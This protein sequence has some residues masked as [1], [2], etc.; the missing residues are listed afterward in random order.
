MAAVMP[1]AAFAS[2]ADGVTGTPLLDS[3]K[4]GVAT[5]RFHI[6]MAINFDFVKVNANLKVTYTPLLIGTESGDTA[7]FTPVMLTGHR[8]HILHSRADHGFKGIELQRDNGK[9]QSIDYAS[10]VSYEPWMDNSML[11]LTDDLCG[12]GEIM[13]R[14]RVPLLAIAPTPEPEPVVLECY[15]TPEVEAVKHRAEKGRAFIDFPVNRTEL[16]PDY[17]RNTQELGKI[18]ATIRLVLENS[19]LEITRV[20]I[21][22][23]ASPEGSYANNTRLASGRARTLA[24]YVKAL[25]GLDDVAMTVES[26]PEDW[27][28]LREYVDSTHLTSRDGLLALIDSNMEPDAKDARMRREYPSDYAFL[29]KEVYPALRHSD[30]EV[31]YT[32]RPF[33][34]EEA[35]EMLRKDPRK[36]SLHEMYMVA[37]S[38]PAGS[39][40]FNEVFEVAVR[41]F[42][43]DA[44]ANLNAAVAAVNRG[45]T[46]SARRYVAKAD[47]LP[48]AS[49]VH[50]AIERIE[51]Q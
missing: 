6:A 17:R 30:Y 29:L 31:E 42:P 45:D 18:L 3:I 25:A 11:Y 16:H 8:Q 26:T 50:A 39:D 2:V 10:S 14:E 23:Y 48:Q 36:L 33:N 32:V 41:M 12:C 46:V 49:E 9:P 27:A 15:L 28:G 1:C 47:S 22:G 13:S 21:H 7:T 4:A 24:D 40:E 44:V 19:D 35:R 43:D 51:E 38:Y 37:Q 20:G 5:D 34:L